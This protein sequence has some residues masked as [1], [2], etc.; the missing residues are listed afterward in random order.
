[1]IRLGRNLVTAIIGGFMVACTLLI[2]FVTV[3]DKTKMDWLGLAFILFAEF[4][5]IGGVVLVDKLARSTF[6]IMFRS[7]AYTTLG[8]YFITS[9]AIAIIFLT[10]LR[11]H[12]RLLIVLQFIVLAIT[13]IIFLVGLSSSNYMQGRN[14]SVLH[15]VSKIQTL[16]NQVTILK[17]N[18]DNK[19]YATQLEKIYEALRYCDNS[20]IVTTDDIVSEKLIELE[21]ALIGDYDEKDSKVNDLAESIL[22]LVKKR[23]LEVN[24]LKAGEI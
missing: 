16:T 3:N 5:F 19:K 13:L 8:S 1:M 11:D 6:G 20:S 21:K 18:V 7:I 9:S 24:E 10:I 17:S 14:Q 22:L 12:M 4:I 15:S 2:F 23:S